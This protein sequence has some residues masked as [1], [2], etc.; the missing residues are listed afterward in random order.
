MPRAGPFHGVSIDG[1]LPDAA[2]R[3]GGAASL[4]FS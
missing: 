3:V 2:V 4:A 1:A